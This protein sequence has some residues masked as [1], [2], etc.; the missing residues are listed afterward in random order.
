MKAGAFDRYGSRAM[1]LDNL[2]VLLAYGSRIQK[3]KAS[4]Q[5]DLFGEAEQLGEQV[6]PQLKLAAQTSNITQRE[7]LQWERE[8]LGLYLSAH[9]LEDYK[10]WLAEQTV[11]LPEV[12]PTLH[13]RSVTVGGVILESREILTKKGQKMAFAKIADETGEM[14][15]ILFPGVYAQS[16]ELWQRDRVV[17]INGKISGEDREGKPSSTAQI[18]V[19]SAREVTPDEAKNYIPTMRKQKA[20]K[21]IKPKTKAASSKEESVSANPR[22]YIKLDDSGN[23]QTLMQLKSIIDQNSGETEVVLVLGG[24][25]SRQVIKLPM[26]VEHSEGVVSTLSEV[27]GAGNIKLR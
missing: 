5:I 10:L 25:D 2:D 17:V 8:L 4:G 6:K 14:E 1:L 24:S 11:P 3:E 18:L 13:G 9:P 16:G 20:P 21:A 12:L 22:L 26:R 27:V 19:D 7:Q 15:L 23:Q